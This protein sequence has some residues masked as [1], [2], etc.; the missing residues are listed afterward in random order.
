MFS[1]M[2][3]ECL[4]ISPDLDGHR[5]PNRALTLRDPGAGHPKMKG[6]Y[7]ALRNTCVTRVDQDQVGNLCAG[8]PTSYPPCWE[9]D[10]FHWER[11]DIFASFLH[12]SGPSAYFPPSNSAILQGIL[13]GRHIVA[14]TACLLCCARPT[15]L[16]TSTGKHS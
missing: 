6:C 3:H 15:K 14:F 12:E 1:R 16:R 11:S 13:I 7:F 5:A 10:A 2:F 9:R 8:K 4:F